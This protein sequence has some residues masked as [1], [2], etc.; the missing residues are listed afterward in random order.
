D[1]TPFSW[2]VSRTSERQTYWSG[3]LPGVQ[4]CSCG[5][6][7]NCIDMNYFCNCDADREEWANDTGLLSY[8]E[9]L[10]VNQMVIGDTSR[11][12]SEAVYRVGPLRCYGD[13]NYWNA[14][15]F[16]METS[17][18]H[19]PTVHA[20][21]SADI[22]FYFK[23]T[24]ESGVFL[25]NMGIKDFIRIE[26][27]SPSDVTFS[28]DVGNGPIEL[29][30]KSPTPLND[31]QWHY[32]KAERNTK[33]AW[34]QVDHLPIRFLEALPDRH[35]R[36][37]L[38]SQLFVGGT[39]SRQKGF[40]G[41]VR[42]LMLNGLTLDLEERAKMTP[43]VQPGC[44]GHCSG[45]GSFCHNGG[46]CIEK[47]NG[48]YCDC[49]HS[50]YR[51][52]LCKKACAGKESGTCT[53][54]ACPLVNASSSGTTSAVIILLPLRGAGGGEGEGDPEVSL[55]FEAGSS[56]TYTFQDPLSVSSNESNLSSAIYAEISKSRENIAFSFLTTSTPAM[57]LSVTTYYHKYM[58]VMLS[59]NGSLQIW[60][61][62][63]T[64][65]EPDVFSTSITNLVNGQLHKVRINRDGRDVYVQIDQKVNTKYSLTSDTEFNSIKSL[66]LGKVTDS[67]GLDEEV[68]VAGAQ[69]FI[70]CLSSVQYNHIAPLKAA[71]HHH[72]SSV[73]TVK[74]R[75]VESSC[76]S[77]S[78]ADLN[79]FTTTH[80]LSG[81]TQDQ[82]QLK[83]NATNY[84]L[85]SIRAATKGTFSALKVRKTHYRR[86]VQTFSVTNLHNLLVTSP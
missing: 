58:A 66:T 76:G 9:H 18:L 70:G 52:P 63:N 56:V 30:V 62:L 53:V 72:R 85:V 78:M 65:K 42:S 79:T 41:C 36:L 28:F 50:A 60:Y 73:V 40:L 44:P 15:S 82:T 20:E 37:Q 59:K 69:G 10:P 2:W 57:L 71:L 13:R 35:F 80:S 38:N 27:S 14:A 49:I 77:T 43:G 39:A 23:T 51:G 1:G 17:Y 74:G 3:S 4:Q 7:E 47:Y 29:T 34:L 31:K 68:R 26:L 19:F 75:L 12:G 46:K 11:T 81:N 5:L 64:E 55:L 86:T 25:E 16:N 48:F 84:R 45:Y 33:E 22:S 24:A 8:K 54:T 67:P 32:V 21:L 61:R 83:M 6:N